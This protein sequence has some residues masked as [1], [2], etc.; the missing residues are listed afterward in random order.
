MVETIHGTNATEEVKKI[1]SSNDTISRRIEDISSDLKRQIL[2][3]FEAPGDKLFV[4]WS[5]QVDESM[6]ISG[7]AQ[8]L[9]FIRFIKDAKFEY[10]YL[11]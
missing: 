2:E 8:L 7:K 4:L 6:D 3:Y 10:E 1:P 9:A 5:H 11:F